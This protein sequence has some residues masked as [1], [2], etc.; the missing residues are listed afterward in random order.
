M[1]ASAMAYVADAASGL[2]H[3][4]KDVLEVGSYDVNG[5]VRP[6]F[7]RYAYTGVDRRE[8]PG[9]DQVAEASHLP[10]LAAQFDVVVST[11]MLEHDTRPWRSVAEMARVLRKRGTLIL[12]AR[13]YDDRGCYEIHDHRDLWRFSVDGMRELVEDA[14]LTVTDAR[15][16]PECP[17]VFLTA[18]K[19]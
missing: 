19:Q 17:G 11:E 18:V 5:S 14:G 4:V 13:G 2:A 15:S 12:T 7:S 1:H 10:F 9:V 16:D 6:I 3:D 8:G